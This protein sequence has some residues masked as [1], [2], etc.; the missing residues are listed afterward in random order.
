MTLMHKSRRR[1]GEA[2]GVRACEML[3]VYSDADNYDCH[4]RR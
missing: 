1:R 3:G 4:I 2:A